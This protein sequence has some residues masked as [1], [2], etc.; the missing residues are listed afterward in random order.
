MLASVRKDLGQ[1]WLC[2]DSRLHLGNEFRVERPPV[3]GGPVRL[4]VSNFD[5]RSGDTIHIDL[6]TFS[7][8]HP[9][10]PWAEVQMVW[11]Q[12]HQRF[13]TV[14]EDVWGEVWV[15]SMEW[16]GEAPVVV[17]FDLHG[18]RDGKPHTASGEVTLPR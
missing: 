12:D 16:D 15:S 9:E 11:T 6:W 17:H 4:V 7:D 10:K 8:N 14:W 2:V 1:S 13:K 5:G 3:A 18:A